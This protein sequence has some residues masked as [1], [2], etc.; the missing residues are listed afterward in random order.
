[1]RN[2]ERFKQAVCQGER[3]AFQ[4]K[5]AGAF[6][7]QALL[8]LQGMPALQVLHVAATRRGDARAS[9]KCRRVTKSRKNKL[10]NQK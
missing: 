7:Q 6:K 9:S 4:R 10:N 1:M 2:I 8:L 3:A 5:A